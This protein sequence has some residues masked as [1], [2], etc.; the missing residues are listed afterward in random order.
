MKQD[1][2]DQN[3]K[4]FVVKILFRIHVYGSF[5]GLIEL[6]NLELL[7]SAKKVAK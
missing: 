6:H 1:V 7:S 4:D 3:Y 2:K 5:T